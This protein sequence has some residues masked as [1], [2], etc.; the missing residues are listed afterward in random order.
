M[1][2]LQALHLLEE[3]SCPVLKTQEAAAILKITKPHASQILRRLSHNSC[4]ISLKRGLWLIDKNLDSLLLAPYIAAPFPSY[5]SLQSALYFH[6]MISQI[7]DTIYLITIARSAY[8]TTAV[9]DFSLHHVNPNFFFGFDSH[10]DSNIR[11]ASPEKA[12]LDFLYLMPST[13]KQF[14]ALPEVRLPVTFNMEKA[15]GMITKITS[16]RTR[17]LVLSKFDILV[18]QNLN[19]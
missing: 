7:P 18:S 3:V 1:N 19:Q 15:Y 12:I 9:A 4:I 5:I 11:L 10:P 13:L 6:D 17:T 14:K 8:L 2:L 16:K